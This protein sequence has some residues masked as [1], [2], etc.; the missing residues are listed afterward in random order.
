MES[1][2]KLT[3]IGDASPFSTPQGKSPISVSSHP[4]PLSQ[5]FKKPE[6]NW[7]C[8]SCYCSNSKDAV[9]CIS[10]QASQSNT[11]QDNTTTET[12]D[13]AKTCSGCIGCNPDSLKFSDLKKPEGEDTIDIPLA[14]DSSNELPS[15]VRLS[16]FITTFSS[17]VNDSESVVNDST[18]ND[19][20]GVNNSNSSMSNFQFSFQTPD[21]ANP[22]SF[23]FKTPSFSF[24]SPD[25]NTSVFGG[26]IFT[27]P[28]GGNPPGST[29]SPFVSPFSQQSSLLNN[30]SS[31]QPVSFAFSQ[32]LFNQQSLVQ[33]TMNDEAVGHREGREEDEYEDVDDEEEDECMF[34][35][36]AH[37]YIRDDADSSE[38][39]IQCH[40]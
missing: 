3:T 33:T 38:G 18:N 14:V 27:P 11:E 26:S 39:V 22:I 28:V 20:K 5:L 30:S 23:Q 25:A 6:G 1:L 16:S 4:T 34:E 10:C 15:V 19:S 9:V 8:N 12:E 17:S 40:S 35:D 31:P 13:N 29:P 32:P 7:T 37:V 24:K 21:K 36:D 2:A